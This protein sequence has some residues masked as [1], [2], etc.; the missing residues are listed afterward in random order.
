MVPRG[1]RN[2]VWLLP[3]Q[4]EWPAGSR[5]ANDGRALQSPLA[6]LPGGDGARVGVVLSLGSSASA[7]GFVLKEDVDGG[8][9]ID[10]GGQHLVVTLPAAP[11]AAAAAGGGAPAKA[12]PAFVLPAEDEEDEEAFRGWE[13]RGVW[14][15][16]MDWM[17]W[18][19]WIASRPIGP[20]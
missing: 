20:S 11:A 4:S 8:A 1:G 5:S 12:K 6:P 18:I 7:V 16:W 14:M 13:A 19:G 9:W 15:V 10:N 17:D 2:D 3:P